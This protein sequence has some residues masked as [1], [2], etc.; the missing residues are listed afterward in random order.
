MKTCETAVSIVKDK[1][2]KKGSVFQIVLNAKYSI[3]IT[4][5]NET[6]TI[7]ASLDSILS[8]ID[9]RFEV[10]VVDS[11]STDGTLEILREYAKKGVIKLIVQKCSRGKGRQIAFENSS[12]EYI[13]SNLDMDDIFAP[14]LNEL[15]KF[16]HKKCEGKLLLVISDLFDKGA[17]NV[18]IAPR[19][20]I[21]QIGGW[22]NLQYSEDW[23]LWSRAAKTGNYCFTNF[24][25][26]ERHCTHP[27]RQKPL[28]KLRRRIRKYV[29]EYR[30]GRRV[31]AKGEHFNAVQRILL[32]I[33][34]FVAFFMKSYKDEFNVYF[35]PYDESYYIPYS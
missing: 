32:L 33:A 12:G 3:C 4:C 2:I 24:N 9:D 13:I 5:R 28:I 10:I 31:I 1:N 30:L 27:E 8:Q 21:S 34:R 14:K 17:Q 20:L 16:Y 23:D 15:I 25:L 26:L 11:R 7:R 22:R 19:L 35:K 29:D 18:T 6:K